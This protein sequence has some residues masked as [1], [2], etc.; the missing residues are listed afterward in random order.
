MDYVQQSVYRYSISACGLAIYSE[1]ESS[2]RWLSVAPACRPGLARENS[3]SPG[4]VR[5]AVTCPHGTPA[6]LR[7]SPPPRLLGGLAS[8]SS[9]SESRF[10][11]PSQGPIS[12]S[13]S[14]LYA[15]HHP[16][17][18]PSPPSTTALLLASA[19]TPSSF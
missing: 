7:S 5:L 19:S 9:D 10:A 15:H 2:N 11:A 14:P 3:R 6:P 12:I 16:P 1:Q 17:T 13:P 18:P 8:L 4:D